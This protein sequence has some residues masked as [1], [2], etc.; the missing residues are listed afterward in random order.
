MPRR[1]LERITFG[2][3]RLGRTPGDLA[4]LVIKHFPGFIFIVDADGTIL[5][6]EGASQR[7]AGWVPGGL[8]GRNLSEIRQHSAAAD[9]AMK[10]AMAS[11]SEIT[12][13]SEFVAPNGRTLYAQ[14]RYIPLEAN[15][16]TLIMG[17]STDETARV[18]AVRQRDAIKDELIEALRKKVD[19]ARKTARHSVATQA[20]IARL[21]DLLEG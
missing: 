18:E 20:S 12:F 10:H 8:V 6:N 17:I 7:A 2:A 14:T 9:R 19:S 13:D 21:D 4:A 16:K 5:M 3:L 1:L 11:G 15:G